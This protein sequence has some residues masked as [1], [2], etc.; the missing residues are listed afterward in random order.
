[1]VNGDLGRTAHS[2]PGQ[3]VDAI[4]IVGEAQIVLGVGCSSIALP[5]NVYQVSRSVMPKLAQFS[6]EWAAKFGA[7]I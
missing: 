7:C 2:P 6:H 5:V 1:M 3:K 4:T